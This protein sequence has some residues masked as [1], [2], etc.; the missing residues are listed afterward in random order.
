MGCCLA[1]HHPGRPPHACLP[2]KHFIVSPPYPSL[3][4]QKLLDL[5]PVG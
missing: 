2:N 5:T 4:S 3:S 1:G